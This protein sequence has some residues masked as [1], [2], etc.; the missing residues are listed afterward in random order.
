MRIPIEIEIQIELAIES[1]SEIDIDIH[2][3]NE[4]GKYSGDSS[5]LDSYINDIPLKGELNNVGVNNPGPRA[6]DMLTLDRPFIDWVSLAS[7][8]GINSVKVDN[9]ETLAKSMKVA[10]RENGPFLIE[11]LM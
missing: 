8:M 10:F 4:K 3:D 2:I 7:G 11:V 9:C 6:I 5:L 1:A